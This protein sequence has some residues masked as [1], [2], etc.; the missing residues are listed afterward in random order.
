M[1]SIFKNILNHLKIKDI[2][3]REFFKDLNFEVFEK[4][5]RACYIQI[6]L[7]TMHAIT[8]TKEIRSSSCHNVNQAPYNLF[9][10]II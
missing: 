5:A 2:R 6:A 1:F 8:Y 3:L 4:L 7:E 9:S 10:S